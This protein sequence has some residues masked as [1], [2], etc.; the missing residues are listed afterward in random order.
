[1]S[2]FRRRIYPLDESPHGPGRVLNC[3]RKFK[4][5]QSRRAAASSARPKEFTRRK[6]VIAV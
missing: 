4:V 5:V 3:R 6:H 2:R 1:L